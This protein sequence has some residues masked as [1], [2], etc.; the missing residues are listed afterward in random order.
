MGPY[1]LPG[2]GDVATH[3]LYLNSCRGG[4]VIRQ[5]DGSSYEQKLLKGKWTIIKGIKSDTD[6]EVYRLEL[7]T[8]AYLY[9]LKGDENIL[10]VL[11][12]NKEFRVGNEDFSYT[13]NRVKLVSGNR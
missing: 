7:G 1:L 12:E 2:S 9:L 13:L 11:D 6:V 5:A 3:N 8:E 10:F 4:D